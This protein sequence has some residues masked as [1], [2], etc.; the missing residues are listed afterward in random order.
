MCRSKQ[1][2][3]RVIHDAARLFRHQCAT[4][5]SNCTDSQKQII[6]LNLVSMS[7]GKVRGIPIH[8]Y[9]KN[10]III[11]RVHRIAWFEIQIKYFQSFHWPAWSYCKQNLIYNLLPAAHLKKI[12]GIGIGMKGKSTKVFA[13]KD[14]WW[15]FV[16]IRL[17]VKHEHMCWI[18]QLV[19]KK[20]LPRFKRQKRFITGYI[21][22]YYCS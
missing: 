1:Y 2:E 8:S 6:E 7:F 12:I 21:L 16:L 10:I 15:P 17:W 9:A 4:R 14:G 18:M 20:L 22:L 13:S 11:I 19:P 3:T 5:C